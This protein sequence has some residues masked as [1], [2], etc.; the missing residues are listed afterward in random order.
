MRMFSAAHLPLFVAGRLTA[1]LLTVHRTLGLVHVPPTAMALKRWQSITSGLP[2]SSTRPGLTWEGRPNHISSCSQFTTPMGFPGDEWGV[3]QPPDW[4]S[5]LLF[6]LFPW[7]DF[8]AWPGFVLSKCFW[9][10]FSKCLACIEQERGFW[11]GFF[12]S[13]G[14]VIIWHR[15]VTGALMWCNHVGG[16]KRTSKSRKWGAS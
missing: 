3:D 13:E 12:Q 1:Y 5:I 11:G 8:Q 10:F 16:G 4:E 9:Y 14:A 2:L 15:A 7:C 6:L